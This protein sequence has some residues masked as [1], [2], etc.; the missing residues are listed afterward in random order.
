[1]SKR[2]ISTEK[3]PIKVWTDDLDDAALGQAKNLANLP[4]AFRHVAI[5]P[6][7]H[8]GY[9]MPIGGVLA[10]KGVVIPNA[11]GVDIGCGMCAVKTSLEEIDRDT[12]KVI[13]GMIREVVPV[14][15]N[16]QKNS[17]DPEWMPN[18]AVLPK[19][20]GQEYYSALKQVGS[21][22][23]G[24][25]FLEIQKGNDGHVWIMIHS[26]SRNL[27]KKV[28][29]FYNR[30]AKH[31]NER[32]F[33]GVDSKQELAFLPVDT[34]EAQQYLDEMSY[35]VEF[36]FLNRKLMMHNIQ[37][38]F[39]EKV[40]VAF[41][42]MINIA[43]NYARYEHHF[44]KDVII[45]RKGATSAKEGEVGIIPGSQGTAS[46]IVKGLGN[47]ESFR[48][49]SHGAGR[50]L[51][52]KAAQKQ[53]DLQA[54]IEKMDSQGIIHGIRCVQDLDEATGAYKDI[55]KVMSNQSDLVEVL[56]ELKPLA[57]IKG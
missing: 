46:Y 1:M 12:L 49:C 52:R 42:P 47:P 48:S 20:V 4:F 40:D 32:W 41:E 18:W 22:G 26:G 23:G 2:V 33:S 45:H 37:K 53:L 3:L 39:A 17:Q 27:G 10:T 54:E 8:V 11:V 24:N 50:I 38:C 44:G 25:H 34:A 30:W 55:S 16:H 51:G 57:V 21:L 19:V 6:D 43:H 13:M 9:G 29:D 35:C 31:L 56:V 5:M 7:G 36:A 14:G 15:F 28:A